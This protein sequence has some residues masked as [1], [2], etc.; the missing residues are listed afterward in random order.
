MPDRTVKLVVIIINY[1]TANLVIQCVVSLLKQIAGIDARVI[2]VDNHSQD[3]S[4]REL[5][6]WIAGDCGS[7]FVDV[8][9]S[10]INGGFSAGNNTGLR[11]VDAEYYLLLNS[12]TIVQPEAV[13]ILLQTAESNTQAGIIS[14]RLEWPDGTPQ[15]SCFRY[16]SPISEFIDAA[17]TGPITS[18]LKK[19]DV[20]LPASDH[21]GHP[22]WTSFAAVLVRRELFDDIGPMDEGFFMYFEDVEFC[23]RARKAGWDI[24]CNPKARIVHLRGGRTPTERKILERERLPRYYYASRARYFY[25]EYGWLGLTLAN[26]LWSLGRCVS[27]CREMLERRNRSVAEKQW[28]DIWTNWS[29]PDAPWS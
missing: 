11:A 23:R 9:E 26:I 28:L 14:P 2:V 27:K 12:D 5:K 8:I 19:F 1:R 29:H 4:V 17:K 16:I 3:G 18:A 24:I 6:N 22:E 21:I 13:A 25:L 20:P 10:E 15:E 7:A